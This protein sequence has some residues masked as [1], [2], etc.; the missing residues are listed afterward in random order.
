MGISNDDIVRINALYNKS[1]LVGLTEEEKEEQKFLRNKYI[2]AFRANLKG[3]LNSIR[4]VDDTGKTRA[5][6]RKNTLKAVIFDMDGVIFDSERGVRDCWEVVAKRHGL[7]DIGLLCDR[8]AGT[9]YEETGKR[10]REFYGEEV[11]YEEYKAECSAL[12][13]EKFDGGKLPIKKG[14]RELLEFLKENQVKLAVASSTREVTV[15]KWLEQGNLLSY[16]D[17]IVCGD[18]VK[19]G[20]P[21]PDIYVKACE[22]LGVTG[23]GVFA[24]EDSYNGVRSANA[25]GIDVIMVP[26]LLPP[27]EEMKR[28]AHKIFEDLLLVME[29]FKSL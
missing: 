23:A 22:E 9:T 21:E 3:Q 4:V 12:F 1:K 8:C 19:A 11:P 5:L 25:A 16:F 10:F 28:T 20:K 18:M 17:K 6:D 15:I 2:A 24:I 13:H 27:T 26:D 7:K 14:V 29:Y